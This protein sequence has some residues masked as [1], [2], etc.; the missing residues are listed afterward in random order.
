M[1][2]SGVQTVAAAQKSCTDVQLLKIYK[3][4]VE[5]NDNR[6][7]ILKFALNVDR[8]VAGILK[9][10]AV[11]DV[12]AERLWWDNFNTATS[13]AKRLMTEEKRILNLLK[14]TFACSGYGI[15]SDSK[16]GFIDVKKNIKIKAWP[17]SVRLTPAPA[18]NLPVTPSALSPTEAKNCK[19]LYKNR[20]YV[21]ATTYERD[22]TRLFKMENLSDCSISFNLSF[23][24]FCPDRNTNLA[25]NSSFPYPVNFKGSYKLEPRQIL[26]LGPGSVLSNVSQKCYLITNR[27]PNLVKLQNSPPT[28][29]VTGVN[30]SSVN[31][32]TAQSAKKTCAVGGSC[33]L[34][35]T[36]PGG[37]IVFYDA[38]SKQSWGRYLEL[39][40]A[41]WNGT[42]MDPK[43]AWCDNTS[44]L[45][46]AITDVALK[47]SLGLEIGK[48]KANTEFMLLKCL[49]G[50]AVVAHS[51]S[52]GGKNDWFLPSQEEL[53]ELCK[54]ARNQTTGNVNVD[55]DK[56]GS[57]IQGFLEYFYWSSSES[58]RK[59]FGEL[60]AWIQD[61]TYGQQNDFSQKKSEFH[62]RPI[63][64]F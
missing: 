9:S 28:V 11:R 1:L 49:S 13:E 31:S 2:I 18:N 8:S 26:E 40:P 63:R 59:Q 39:A 44:A 29:Q 58:T 22:N 32:T 56:H 5:F 15:Q 45:Y 52:G 19:T 37:G 43:A 64:S 3:L 35:S 12:A 6:S 17:L 21:D 23:D 34:G 53:N 27:N 33:P 62:V 25:T 41:G 14:N 51:Y 54:Y 30:A 61:F 60:T 36:G 24:V 10:Q 57:L 16:N 50:S 20:I 4:A 48:G 47:A 46:P 42:E 7:Y 38:G 55:C